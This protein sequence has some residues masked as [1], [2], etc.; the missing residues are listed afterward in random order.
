ML[1]FT[2]YWPYKRDVFFE[3]LEDRHR[4]AYVQLNNLWSCGVPGLLLLLIY[5]LC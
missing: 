3:D 5:S 2:F 1:Y 4:V